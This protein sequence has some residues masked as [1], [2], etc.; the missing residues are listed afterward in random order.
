MHLGSRSVDVQDE[1]TSLWHVLPGS[2]VALRGGGCGTVA[3]DSSDCFVIR[4]HLANFELWHEEDRARM[5]SAPDAEI[6]AVKRQIDALNQRRHDLTEQLDEVLL[7]MAHHETWNNSA[8]LL[9]ETPG[10]MIDRLSILSLKVFHTEEEMARRGAPDG[11]RQ[12][13]AGRLLVLQTQRRDLAHVLD[14]VWSDIEQGRARFQLYKQLKMYND[15]ELNP[16][17]YGAVAQ[18]THE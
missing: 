4:Q 13:N 12:R 17:V 7:D 3:P 15:A 16:A 1:Y 14:R 5:P 2:D 10:M 18:A 8:P 9:S 6:A 11:H